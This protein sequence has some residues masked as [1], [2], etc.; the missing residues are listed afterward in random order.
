MST[1][2]TVHEAQ[3]IREEIKTLSG[4]RIPGR[5]KVDIYELLEEFNERLNS[6]DERK[7][8]LIKEYG[9]D[10]QLGP[11]TGDMDGFREEWMPI[12]EEE[13]EFEGGIEPLPVAAIPQGETDA[14]IPFLMQQNIIETPSS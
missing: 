12:A 10:G 6:Y 8:D 5:T 7:Q 3:T 2:L 11:N 1:T 9:E 4:A 14:N 13:I